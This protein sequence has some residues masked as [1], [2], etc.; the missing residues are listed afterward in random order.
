MIKFFQPFI[1]VGAL[2][3]TSLSFGQ[4]YQ[5]AWQIGYDSDTEV[6]IKAMDSDT[7]GNLYVAGT[8]LGT[9]DFDPSSD[10]ALASTEYLENSFVVKY[11]ANGDY[12]WHI[13]LRGFYT[14]T[15][16][17]RSP[18]VRME[19]MDVAPNGDVYIS[20]MFA[21]FMKWVDGAGSAGGSIYSGGGRDI[22]VMKFNN[23]GI[24]QW[25]FNIFSNNNLNGAR[26]ALHPDLDDVYVVAQ[27]SKNSNNTGINVG[28]NTELLYSPSLN[29]FLAK[30]ATSNGAYQWAKNFDTPDST[31]LGVSRGM[32]VAVASTGDVY[33][34]GSAKREVDFDMG[35]GQATQ[36]LGDY[37]DVYLAKYDEDG[38]YLWAFGVGNETAN[39]YGYRVDV[40]ASDRPYVAG[41]W[42]GNIKLDSAQ[43]STTLHSG[44]GRDVFL[45][46]YDT[47][48]SL[49]WTGQWGTNN[50]VERP[51][52]LVDGNNAIYLTGYFNGQN[53]FDAN[54]NGGTDFLSAGGTSQDWFLIKLGTDKSYQWSADGQDD[55]NTGVGRALALVNGN[56]AMGGAFR[57]SVD[58]D[59]TS[60][61]QWLVAEGKDGFIAVFATGA[62]ARGGI[63][64]TASGTETF[65][66]VSNDLSVYPNPFTEG[67]SVTWTGN[68]Q[69]AKVRLLDNL[70][71]EV[72]GQMTV[73]KNQNYR[74]DAAIQP[75]VYF[76]E[77]TVEGT[78]QVQRI[79]RK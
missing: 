42:S 49:R 79:I 57:D 23:S 58:I 20:G 70:G 78:T 44:A 40:D 68:D 47:D 64:Q 2:L 7:A 22:Y 27:A 59:Q 34:V 13:E 9:V 77:I 69:S 63:A 32:D 45:A 76:L 52:V 41:Y 55:T 38:N 33:I 16:G 74:V 50:D 66:T 65:A 30:Y 73:N 35:S 72:R 36:D 54:P 46:A 25:H 21:T 11:D 37:E 4:V 62:H 29:T 6:E 39:N 28:S 24:R 12:V 31:Y 53:Y 17:T 3:L 75:G 18:Y 8:W 14:A 19:D 5:N 60:A 67:F 26:I 56:I 51:D 48:G 43:T 71:R 15:L 1:L 61:R 10:S